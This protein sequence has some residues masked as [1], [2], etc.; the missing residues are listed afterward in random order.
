[1]QWEGGQRFKIFWTLHWSH[2]NL[3]S[4]YLWGCVDLYLYFQVRRQ[5]SSNVTFNEEDQ[6]K[7]I[8]EQSGR[9][10]SNYKPLVTQRKGES[11]GP[12]DSGVTFNTNNKLKKFNEQKGRKQVKEKSS[13]TQSRESQ[14]QLGSSNSNVTFNAKDQVKVINERM[15]NSRWLLHV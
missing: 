13:L 11:P 6:V 14:K 7:I 8:D 2:R 12:S 9:K 4:L 10:Q 1:M 3:L 15:V 5:T